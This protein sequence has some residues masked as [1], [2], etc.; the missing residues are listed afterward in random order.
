LVVARHAAW[1]TPREPAQRLGVS[2]VEVARIEK[3]GYDCYTS[4]TLWRYMRALDV[5]SLIEVQV[6][7]ISTDTL[8]PHD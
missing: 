8:Q 4:S 5:G 2:H 7:R 1:L 6:S 3:R